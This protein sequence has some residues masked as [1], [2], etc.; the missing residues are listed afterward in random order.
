MY[1]ETL[2]LKKLHKTKEFK[3]SIPLKKFYNLVK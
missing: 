3:E 1:L 2:T